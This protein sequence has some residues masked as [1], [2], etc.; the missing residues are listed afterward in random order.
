[1]AEQ[2]SSFLG[3]SHFKTILLNSLLEFLSFSLQ[4]K[5]ITRQSGVTPRAVHIY[6]Q[7]VFW[8]PLCNLK[9]ADVFFFFL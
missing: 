8:L 5:T 1:M 2:Q 6:F 7:Q 4:L 3:F 9:L